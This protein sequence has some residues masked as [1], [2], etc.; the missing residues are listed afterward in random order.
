M[1]R[2]ELSFYYTHCFCEKN[3]SKYSSL[4]LA[5]YKNQHCWKTDLFRS[6]LSEL[7]TS[8]TPDISR[9]IGIELNFF[10]NSHLKTFP[11]T[12]SQLT[13]VTA[14]GH[15]L[16]NAQNH[17]EMDWWQENEHVQILHR[18]TVANNV[19]DR[20]LKRKNAKLKSVQVCRLGF[21]RLFQTILIIEWKGSFRVLI[22]NRFF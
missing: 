11:L 3:I 13:V 21:L 20:P 14:H 10:P 8:L 1:P 15:H 22:I 19:K 2:L 4:M 9:F 18:N 5:Y 16:V 17:V 12:I 6:S 7:L